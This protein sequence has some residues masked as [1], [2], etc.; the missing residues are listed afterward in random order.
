MAC[1]NRKILPLCLPPHITHLLQP[2][3]VAIFEPLQKIYDDLV[4]QESEAG[5]DSIN[6]DIFI[7]LYTEAREKAFTSNVI[8]AEF[9]ATGLVSFNP[10]KVLKRFPD[11]A[12]TSKT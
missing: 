12:I 6:K 2:L 5:I 4:S 3:D 1:H 11:R 10:Q 7:N 8:K 9:K